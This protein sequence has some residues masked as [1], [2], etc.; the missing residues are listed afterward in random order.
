M[1]W[2]DVVPA[3]RIVNRFSSDVDLLDMQIPLGLVNF[4]FAAGAILS[5]LV[6][7]GITSPW[8]LVV[9][10]LGA[11]YLAL[12]ARFYLNASRELQRLMSATKAPIYQK[13][14][15][16]LQGLV[17]IRAF[18]VE[19]QF[20]R[21]I[22]G[23]MDRNTRA[24][25][26]TPSLNRWLIVNSS[27]LS[28]CFILGVGLVAVLMRG[29]TLAGYIGLGMTQAQSLTWTFRNLVVAI[30]DMETK[31]VAIERIRQYSQVEQEA[32]ADTGF[33]TDAD[34]PAKGALEFKDY[35]TTYREGLDP[36]LRGLS[37][38]IPP[39]CKVGV[40]GRTG[41]GKSSLTLAL[42]RIIESIS[43]SITLDG[44]DI[45]KIGLRQL[46]SQLCII[47]QDP[48][49]F[50]GTIRDNLDP[51]NQHDDAAL[52]RAL[53]LA[54][55]SECVSGLEG[56]LL[57]E[58]AHA[59][60]NFSAGQKQ[61]VTLASAILRKRKVVIFD[62]ATS[63]TDAETDA[64]VQRT[65]RQEFKDCTILTI[66]HRINTIRDSD[67]ILVLD[68]G[69]VAEYDAPETLLRD[70]ESLFTKLVRDSESH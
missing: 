53:E 62:E 56:K 57:G 29:S 26:L 41:A 68:R 52:W 40:V 6:I 19:Q 66:A 4:M 25:Y 70:P 21:D 64:V 9:I 24:A 23:A 67:R 2:Y 58:V 59:G 17:S 54:S 3:G 14:E 60:S 5:S 32:P 69:Q 61:L 43:G 34:W 1:S 8:V 7:L 33:V 10:P 55:M 16:T 31:M 42:F 63:S 28:S 38:A 36:V 13:F 47:P 15:E 45:S 18:Q 44:V 49:L 12:I 20:T 48:M 35:S 50:E 11:M 46:R 30:C 27:I 37:I 22:S 51:L 65:I 39:G